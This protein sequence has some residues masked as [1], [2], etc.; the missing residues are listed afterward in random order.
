LEQELNIG[1]ES[2]I[3]A[4]NLLLLLHFLDRTSSVPGGAGLFSLV[5]VA[6]GYQKWEPGYEVIS[7]PNELQ[8]VWGLTSPQS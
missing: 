6:G 2:Q 3:L 5:E 1:L 4:N 7:R 8:L